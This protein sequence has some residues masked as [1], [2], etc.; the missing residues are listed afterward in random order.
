MRSPAP[1]HM[2]R[3]SQTWG[4][5]C[6]TLTATNPATI[7]QDEMSIANPSVERSRDHGKSRWGSMSSR[8]VQGLC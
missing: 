4:G 8:L 6:W 1:S 2:S 5:G 3:P 7:E